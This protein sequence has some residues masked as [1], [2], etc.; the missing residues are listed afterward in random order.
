MP[1]AQEPHAAVD[2]LE[3]E[4]AARREPGVLRRAREA[5]GP[6]VGVL[7]RRHRGEPQGSARCASA[8][9]DPRRRAT[10]RPRA[11]TIASW[12]SSRVLTACAHEHEAVLR[13]GNAALDHDLV[14]FGV[15]PGDPQVEDR[16]GLVAVLAAHLQVGERA[17]RRHVRTNRPAVAAVLVGAVRVRAGAGEVPA[18]HDAGEAAAARRA[19]RVDD[20]CRA[21]RSRRA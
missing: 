15:D 1:R 2:L 4:D 12:T 7:A 14:L 13:A 5:V 8:W 18:A 10:V 9:P 19:A 17:P 16:D 3:L 11:V 20:T 6:G 21:G